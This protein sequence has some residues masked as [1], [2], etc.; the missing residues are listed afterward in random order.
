MFVESRIQIAGWP[1]AFTWTSRVPKCARGA[2]VSGTLQVDAL[3][4][5]W[6][7]GLHRHHEGHTHRPRENTL[8]SLILGQHI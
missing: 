2:V 3:E 8:P 5:R 7:T 6:E 4:S 1:A